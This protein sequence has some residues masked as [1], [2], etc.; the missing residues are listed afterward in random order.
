MAFGDAENDL[1]LFAVAERAVAAR[2]SVPAV[3]RQAQDALS[4]PNG[5]GVARMSTRC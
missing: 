3:A 2:G 4:Q 1:P 5:P